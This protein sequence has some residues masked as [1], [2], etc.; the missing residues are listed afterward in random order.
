MRSQKTLSHKVGP[1]EDVR[2]LSGV[3]CVAQIWLIVWCV[4]MCDESHIEY[5]SVELGL[6]TNFLVP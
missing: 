4:Q 6:T 1:N 5:L 2:D 3:E